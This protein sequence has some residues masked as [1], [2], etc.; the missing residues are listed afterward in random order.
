M[1]K[2]SFGLLVAFVVSNAV[3][4]YIVVDCSISMMYLQASYDSTNSSL[5]SLVSLSRPLFQGKSNAEI[6]DLA[7]AHMVNADIFEKPKGG[8]NGE[9]LLVVEGILFQLDQDGRVE[10]ISGG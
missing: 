10:R 1:S 2:T 3:W 5:T 8:E 4:L 6:R 7:K 9:D